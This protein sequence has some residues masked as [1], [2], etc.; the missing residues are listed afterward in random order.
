MANNTQSNS[1]V[2]FDRADKVLA[3]CGARY[4]DGLVSRLDFIEKA[5]GLHVAKELR[6]VAPKGK[7]K[8]THTHFAEHAYNQWVL[9]A[10]VALKKKGIVERETNRISEV[11][12]VLRATAA[13]PDIVAL[14]R[15]ADTN[16][17]AAL[18][19]EYT[20]KT[21]D[22]VIKVARA[23]ANDLT[24][25]LTLNAAIDALRPAEKEFDEAKAVKAV[26]KALE[27]LAK[28]G[29]NADAYNGALKILVPLVSLVEGDAARAKFIADCVKN[30]Y[31]EKDAAA[32]YDKRAKAA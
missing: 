22:A 3:D 11:G 25:P 32:F 21:Y 19:D 23:Q 26:A 1:E 8:V 6:H 10:S 2:A 7:G 14:G 17:R 5:A 20:V 28:E 4:A 27:K 24:V 16:C 31:T 30:G 29:S 15:E 13:K 9:R 18:G 12:A